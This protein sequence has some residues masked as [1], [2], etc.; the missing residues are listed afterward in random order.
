MPFSYG[1]PSKDHTQEFVGLAGLLVSASSRMGAAL[2]E[3]VPCVCGATVPKRS[4][5]RTRGTFVDA[6]IPTRTS[7]ALYVA[8]IGVAKTRGRHVLGA[9]RAPSFISTGRGGV[10]TFDNCLG[11]S[12]SVSA[13]VCDCRSGSGTDSRLIVT[14]GRTLSCTRGA[15][16]RLARG[17]CRALLTRVGSTASYCAQRTSVRRVR[18][19][20]TSLARTVGRYHVGRAVASRPLSV[21][22]DCLAGTSFRQKE[23]AK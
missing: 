23:A 11:C 10:P 6:T 12:G 7:S 16:R 20:A 3:N 13:D 18:G 22:R 21:A 14:V 19:V 4:H 5:V 2:G 8:F 1:I 15:R 9:S 17:S